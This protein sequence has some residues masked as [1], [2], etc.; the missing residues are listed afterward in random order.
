[1]A[2]ACR[3]ASLHPLAN[4][5]T[6]RI[7]DSSRPWWTL[8][9]ACTGLFVLML[10]STIVALALPSIKHDIGAS[11]S[12][13][14]WVMNGYL[15]V[16][17]ALVVTGGRIGDIFGRR[18]VFTVGLVIFAAGSVLSGAAAGEV[19]IVLG[20]VVQGI[21]AAAMLPLSLAIVCDAFP[22]SEQPRALGI[23]AAVSALA[24]AVGPL[25]GGLLVDLDWRL[26]FWINVP[27]LAVGV[28]IMLIAVAETR[29]ETATRR[30]DI[31]GLILLAAGLTALIMPLVESSA[32]GLGS[33]RSIGILAAGV[34]LLGAFWF[35][36]H[37][38]EQPIVDFPLFRNGPYFGASAAA[39]CLVGPY[40]SLIF[41]QPQY[42]QTT[43]GHSATMTG[44]LILPVTVPMILIS[45][46]AGRLIARFGARA[47]MTAGMICGTAGLLFLTR[48]SNASG[49]GLVLPGYLLFG[50]ALG[51]VYAPMSTAAMVA[52]PPE[53]TGIASGVLAMNR[54]L[55]GALALAA[56]GA[57]LHGLLDDHS[58]PV[59]LAGSSWVLVGLMAVGAALTWIFVRSAPTTPPNPAVAGSPPPSEM[60]HHQHHR[61][62]HL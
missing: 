51:L 3:G 32:W 26:I 40:W 24:L 38:V 25:I 49:Y 15:L 42:L 58:F 54:V 59:A 8:A 10:D 34:V 6:L 36:E 18:A 1:V 44:L 60:H 27:I 53:K 2:A 12:G 31:A 14:Q 48:I 57:V 11:T 17:A 41:F 19:A 46:L 9:G 50:V 7:T 28:A 30:L 55:A 13:L 43:L 45:P 56:S 61:R 21:G 35:A 62:F 16:I 47:L 37:R 5:V 52:M 20:R 22:S 4:A 29:D 23:W 33:A 39:F